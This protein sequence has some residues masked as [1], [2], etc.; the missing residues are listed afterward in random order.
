MLE[1][2][3]NLPRHQI[4]GD[5]GYD[6]QRNYDAAAALKIHAII[7]LVNMPTDKKTKQR[8]LHM[9]KRRR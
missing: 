7:P 5:K 2:H 1:M 3:P 6:S 9:C 4:T 8:R